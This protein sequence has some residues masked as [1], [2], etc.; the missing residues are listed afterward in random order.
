MIGF[1]SP[2]SE[3]YPRPLGDARLE[4]TNAK[5]AADFQE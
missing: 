2:E 5:I 4:H 1:I 3:G